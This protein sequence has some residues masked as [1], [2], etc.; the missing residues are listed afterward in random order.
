MY[1]IAPYILDTLFYFCSTKPI[2]LVN[3]LYGGLVNSK[4]VP[5][6]III[7]SQKLCNVIR[8]DTVDRCNFFGPTDRRMYVDAFFS[9]QAYFR[10]L[11]RL[12]HRLLLY[13]I[14]PFSTMDLGIKI[15]MHER[16]CAGRRRTESAPR[17]SKC[18]F[19]EILRRVSR[20]MSL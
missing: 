9:A 4:G 15:P 16:C 6:G 18:V 3:I 10:F 11:K 7:L 20:R 14:F 2:S 1:R 12:S 13:T 5:S 8:T 17:Q 19:S